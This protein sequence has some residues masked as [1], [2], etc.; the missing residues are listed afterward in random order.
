ML[1]VLLAHAVATALAPLLVAKWGRMAFYPLALVA[2]GFSGLGR[3][4][5]AQR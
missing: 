3:G 4:E 1:A 5:L 2:L